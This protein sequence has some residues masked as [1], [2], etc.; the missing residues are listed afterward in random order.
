MSKNETFSFLF[1]LLRKNILPES[2]PIVEGPFGRPPFEK[3]SIAK[4]VTNFVLYKFNHLPPKDWQSMYDLA[5]LFLHLLNHWKLV[6][7][8]KMEKNLTAEELQAYKL[9]FQRW[10]CY[11]RV[12]FYCDSL[13]RFDTTLIFGRPFLKSVFQH[14]RK[15]LGEFKTE[16]DFKDGTPAKRRNLYLTH[17]PNFLTLLEEELYSEKSPIWDP[18]FRLSPPPLVTQVINTVRATTSQSQPTSK[19]DSADMD[20]TIENLMFRFPHLS[21]MIFDHLNNQ[22]LADCQLVSK[23]LNKYL[24]EQKFHQ[25]R[26]INETVKKFQELRQPWIN[27]FKKANTETIM[28]LGCAVSHFYMQEGVKYL[29]YEGVTPLHIAAAEGNVSLYD[30]IIEHAQNKDQIDDLGFGPMIIAVG[31]G[32]VEMTK[33]IMKKSEDKNPKAA[34]NDLTPLHAAAI[35]GH[36]EIFIMILTE[37]EDKTPRDTSGWTP[38]HSAAFYGKI[39]VCKAFFDYLE[40]KNSRSTTFSNQKPFDAEK[41]PKEINKLILDSDYVSKSPLDYA[42]MNNHVD[43]CMLLLTKLENKN[44]IILLN[45]LVNGDN[46]TALHVA[47]EK[48]Y[49]DIC[50]FILQN[51]GDKNP[52]NS[53]GKT[54]LSLAAEKNHINVCILI[55]FHMNKNFLSS[56]GTVM[57]RN[58]LIPF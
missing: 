30:M 34:H 46:N 26:I 57:I 32:Q 21:V 39:N 13:A 33:A 2:K 20:V 27:V 52:R 35:F 58:F 6:V 28:K 41:G 22:S 38:L 40:G 48:G 10:L 31:N 53:R 47:A 43:V 36:L 8:N 25:I 44:P 49:L 16:K 7:P 12:P 19:M 4:G 37:A 24:S 29:N 18:D 55:C 45:P 1:Q 11:N 9:N 23:D 14:M 51:V 50:R 17:F 5:K 15:K 56:A 3:P 54:P 42:F